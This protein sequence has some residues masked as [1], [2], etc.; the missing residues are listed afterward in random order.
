MIATAHQRVAE[1]SPEEIE[2]AISSGDD[3]LLLDVYRYLN[4]PYFGFTPRPDNPEEFDEQT[5]ALYDD[6]NKFVV[7]LGGNGAGKTITAAQ[8]TANYLRNTTPYREHCPFWIIGETKEMVMEICWVE[9]LSSLI[10]VDMIADVVWD[11]SKKNWPS[12]VLLK[13]PDDPTKVGWV[14][15]FKSYA[16]GREQFQG[17]SIGGFWFNEE[18]PLDIVEEVIARCR[19]YDSPGWADFTPLK[20]KSPEWAKLYNKPPKSW[21]FYHLNTAKNKALPPGWYERFISGI[22]EDMIDTRTI[23]TFGSLRGQ[24]YKE[25]RWDIHVVKS[26]DEFEIPADWMKYRGIDF[27][28]SDPYV[29]LWIAQDH[30]KRWYVYDE[31]YETQQLHDHHAKMIKMRPW[32][33]TDPTCRETYSDHDAQERAELMVRGITTMLANKSIH[34]GIDVVRRAMMVKGDKRPSLY[35]FERCKHLIDEIPA[36]RWMEGTDKRNPNQLPYDV[37]NHCLDA[38]R[39]V[40]ASKEMPLNSQLPKHVQK[41]VRQIRQSHE[42]SGVKMFGGAIGAMN[43]VEKRIRN[44]Y[45]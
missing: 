23:G 25:W 41:G 30:D 3:S 18:C 34:K 11:Q 33:S 14:I 13:H 26:E 29:C 9:K 6:V 12:S 43:R 27:G 39:M 31:Y 32:P 17:H 4:D 42:E 2:L 37:D 7:I 20:I 24:V 10:P 21:R 45:G 35:V 8:K 1:L 15:E 44:L 19:D 38:L 16:Q 5:S 22:P 36:Y 28:Y 40:L